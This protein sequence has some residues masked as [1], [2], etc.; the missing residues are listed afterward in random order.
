MLQVNPIWR[1]YKF[2]LCLYKMVHFLLN[3]AN[4]SPLERLPTLGLALPQ[5]VSGIYDSCAQNCHVVSSWSHVYSMYTQHCALCHMRTLFQTTHAHFFIYLFVGTNIVR[6]CGV[7]RLPNWLLLIR[8][9][10]NIVS[11]VFLCC[12]SWYSNS[13]AYNCNLSVHSNCQFFNE[14]T[15]VL[16]WSSNM[17]R[18]TFNNVAIV[19]F[20]F[21]LW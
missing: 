1:N 6:F 8:H 12:I 21:D 17:I 15:F 10:P 4:H 18:D 20:L 7:Y 11:F 9:H 13:F 2:I 14:W 3:Q 19:G 16:Y 5:A